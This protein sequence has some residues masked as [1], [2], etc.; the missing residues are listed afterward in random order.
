MQE[1]KTATGE[2]DAE[3]TEDDLE[4]VSGGTNNSTATR[5]TSRIKLDGVEGESTSKDHK[6][7]IEILSWRLSGPV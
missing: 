4:Q 3:L 6:G 2:N 1:D 5:A 7:E